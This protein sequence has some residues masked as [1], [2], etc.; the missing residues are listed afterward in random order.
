MAATIPI[1]LQSKAHRAVRTACPETRCNA[2]LG[3]ITQKVETV[4]GVT[5]TYDYVYDSADRLARVDR[6]GVTVES[7]AYGQNGNRLGGT[8]DNQDRL[9]STATASYTYTANG[10]LATKT[11]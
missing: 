4:L 1:L 10:E 2:T 8:Y 9:L 3:R 11:E 7:Y 5:D 6:N